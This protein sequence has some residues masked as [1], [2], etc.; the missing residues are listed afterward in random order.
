M[1]DGHEAPRGAHRPPGAQCRVMSQ[2]LP[3]QQSLLSTQLLPRAAQ[4]G[5]PLRQ[6]PLALGL[7]PQRY[8]LQHSVS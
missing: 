2:T 4:L 3:L 7:P 5:E 1:L 6:K 8:P